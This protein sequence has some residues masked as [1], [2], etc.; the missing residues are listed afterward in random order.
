MDEVLGRTAGTLTEASNLFMNRLRVPG[1]YKPS[2]AA[3]SNPTSYLAKRTGTLARC[4]RFVSP[5]YAGR[6]GWFNPTTT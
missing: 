4:V 1:V 5:K 3:R 2:F 6:A